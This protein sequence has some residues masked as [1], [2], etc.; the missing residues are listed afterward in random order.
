MNKTQNYASG[1]T[2]TVERS[3][4]ELDG[5]LSKHGASSRGIQCDDAAGIA[6]VAFIMGGHKYRIE[7]PLP[8]LSLDVPAKAQPRG[9]SGW[10]SSR[11]SDY[12][13]KAW[14][15][16]CRERWRALVLTVKAKLEIIKIGVS[17]VQREFMADLVLSDG[18]T[19]HQH[20]ATALEDAALG[21][22]KQGTS[23]LQLPQFASATAT[24]N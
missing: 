12:A 8:R 13:T 18:G 4:M 17:S 2:V 6:M 1:T 16:A 14:Q 19:L 20:I 23:G 10:S 5:L 7:L 22:G 9:W 3:R 15:Q 11:R 24:E 21:R